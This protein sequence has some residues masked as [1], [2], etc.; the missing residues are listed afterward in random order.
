VTQ[1][2]FDIY[3][4]PIRQHIRDWKSIL[5]RLIT[6]STHNFE[7]SNLFDLESEVLQKSSSLKSKLIWFGSSP[8]WWEVEDHVWEQTNWLCQDFITDGYW[9]RHYQVSFR[10]TFSLC[11]WMHAWKRHLGGMYNSQ[12]PNM[13]H[14]SF[15]RVCM[16]SCPTHRCQT[17]IAPWDKYVTTQCMFYCRPSSMTSI[18]L[19][20][21][22]VFFCTKHQ[23]RSPSRI[24]EMA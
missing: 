4:C 16:L 2:F 5:H 17:L 23:G 15:Q 18:I 10:S 19:R 7:L 21:R 8:I 3:R 14:L 1:A 12:F 22:F 13:C 20:S 6:E 9:R 24:T 11:L